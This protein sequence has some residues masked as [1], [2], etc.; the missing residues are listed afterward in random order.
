ML[1][2]YNLKNLL[3]VFWTLLLLSINT[4]ADFLSKIFN[5]QYSFNLEYII[6][7]LNLIRFFIPFLIF[8]FLIYL[9]LLNYKKINKINKFFYILFFYS[10]WQIIIFYL[11]NRNYNQLFNTQIIISMF[12]IIMIFAIFEIYNL[13]NVYKNLLLIFLFY[14]A[15]I[16]LIYLIIGIIENYENYTLYLYYSIDPNKNYLHQVSPRITG[17]SRIALILFYFFCF[18]YTYNKKNNKIFIFTILNI[19][20]LIIYLSQSRGTYIGFVIF[21]IYYLLFI[22]KKILGKI[23]FVT[24]LII[25][26]I[27]IATCLNY[28]QYKNLQKF[29]SQHNIKNEDK[30]S[31]LERFNS[32]NN[33]RII[34]ELKDSGRI[35]IW[36]NSI[37]II[38][39]EKIILGMGPQS[40]RYLLEKHFKISKNIDEVFYENNSSNALIYSLLCGG[41]IGFALLLAKYYFLSSELL[42][43]LINKVNFKSRNMLFHF[44]YI[45]ILFLMVRSIFEN[46]FALFSVDYCLIL[47]CY[48]TLHKINH[49]KQ[50]INFL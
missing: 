20:S 37:K 2:Y 36:K 29:I 39:E 1:K 12:C 17:L 11:N 3:I 13:Q 5:T 6:N 40:D 10:L 50:S 45:T 25:I 7:S 38:L 23:I 32:R 31:Y 27:F 22:R 35:Q 41:I 42:K 15:F 30:N 8:F 26:P 4:N 19:L 49:S 48:F 33:I 43:T 44:S 18:Y 34:N 14:T 28:L 46:S 24:S 21:I 47:L 9:I 16:L